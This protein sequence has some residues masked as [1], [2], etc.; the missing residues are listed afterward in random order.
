MAGRQ[1]QLGLGTHERE[2]D[3]DLETSL[4]MKRILLY[5]IPIVLG[6]YSVMP[7]TEPEPIHYAQEM[8]IEEAEPEVVSDDELNLYI[9]VYGAM[10]LDHSLTIDDAL[11]SHG[12]TVEAFRDLERRIQE[13]E[14]LVTRV[15][16]AL[17]E[18]AKQRSAFSEPRP[19]P[20]K[21]P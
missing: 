16:E 2:R 19:A 15:R 4:F 6:I 11:R 10:Q 14:R 17:V 9:E 1:D 8:P 18:Q 21:K 13:K 5:A 20:E 7:T 3:P 12:M